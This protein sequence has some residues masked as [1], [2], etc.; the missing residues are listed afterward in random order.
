M[1]AF[2][3]FFQLSKAFYAKKFRLYAYPQYFTTTRFLFT[4]DVQ[5]RLGCAC[6]AVAP[7]TSPASETSSGPTSSPLRAPGRPPSPQ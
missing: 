4:A 5:I 3:Y 6:S 1:F 2:L 7:A